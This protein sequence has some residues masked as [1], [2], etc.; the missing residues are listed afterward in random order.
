M[1]FFAFRV[2]AVSL[3]CYCEND[4]FHDFRYFNYLDFK[5]QDLSC[6]VFSIRFTFWSLFFILFKSQ[7]MLLTGQLPHLLFHLKEF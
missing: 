6:Y 4:K 5:I 2:M 7:I 3:Y 1:R